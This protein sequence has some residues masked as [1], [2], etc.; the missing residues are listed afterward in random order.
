MRSD[1]CD[2]ATGTMDKSLLLDGLTTSEAEKK[3]E[4][5]G[6]N[7]LPTPKPPGFGLIFLRQF[8]SPF[9]YVL[10][11]AAAISFALGQNINSYF[12]FAVLLLNATI[13]TVQEFAAERAADAL[14]KLVPTVARVKRNGIV[15]ELDT[16]LLVPGDVVTLE[17]GDKV[18]ADI[19]M[20]TCRDLTVDESMLTGE[21]QGVQKTQAPL[22]SLDATEPVENRDHICFA[23]TVVNRGRGTGR[24]IATGAKTEI[25]SIAEDVAKVD[26]VKPPLI[27]RMEKFTLRVSYAMMAVITLIFILSVARGDDLSSVFLLS[28]S[29]MVS[30]IPEGL[31]AA[32]TVALAIGMQRMAKSNVIIRK[33]AAVESL[34]SCTFI[35]SDKTGTL[36]VNELTVKRIVLSDGRTLAIE[37]DSLSPGSALPEVRTI[38]DDAPVCALAKTGALANEAALTEKD[39]TIDFRGDMVDVAFLVLA[40]K[41]NLDP[42]HLHAEAPE[43]DNIPYESENAYSAAFN[44]TG[45]TTI[46]HVKGALEKIL[47][48]CTTG[49]NNQPL[50]VP[51]L[52]ETA[53]AIASKGYRLLA[54]AAGTCQHLPSNPANALTGLEFLGFVGIIDPVRPEVIHALEQCRNAQ[55]TSAMVT[56]DHPNTAL[57]IARELGLAGERDEAVT[58]TD[59]T[60]AEQRG[61]QALD[62]AITDHR[63]FARVAPAQKRLIVDRLIKHGEYVAVTGDG[64]NDAPALH[65]AH[66]GVAMGKRGTDVARESADLILTDDNFASIV[67]GIREG[68]IVYNNIRKVIFLLI[69]TGAGEITLFLWSI[70]LGLPLP[71]FPLQLLW[72]NLVTN[73]VQD[74]ALAFEPAEGDELKR[75]PRRPSESIF[76][77]LMVER[78]VISAA[79]LGTVAFVVFYLILQS[80]VTEEYARNVTLLLMV[81]FENIH[82][83]NSRSETRSLLHIPVFSNPLLLAGIVIAQSIHIGA[84]YV[85]GLSDILQIEPVPFTLWL[86]LLGIAATLFV[87]DEGHKLWLARKNARALA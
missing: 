69:S 50:N 75:P 82:A 47:P 9:I 53:N 27:A 22:G 45:E 48:M 83:L 46:V 60:A 63:V 4:E 86:K 70:F 32:I 29:L 30:A 26:L 49:F 65:H 81:L 56:G 16:A 74:V 64:V 61:P 7:E 36:T 35:A 57:A 58:G 73:G 85:P 41:L 67:A 14:R 42:R 28:V 79:Y 40:R 11:I 72:L 31:P 80:G 68:R 66:V 33:L 77:R 10:L 39:G 21:S 12:V 37:T 19:L 78:V 24:I 44:R 5:F 59:L 76:D 3:L 1:H 2:I 25:G 87:I 17:S 43:I 20:H 8:R 15:Q 51:M 62:E 71:L 55:I 52:M 23:G 18:P 38:G 34:G 13:G 84:M 54:V 6:R